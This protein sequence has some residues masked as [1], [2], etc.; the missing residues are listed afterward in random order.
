MALWKLQG[1]PSNI[2]ELGRTGVKLEREL[3]KVDNA[4]VEKK[5]ARKERQVRCKVEVEVEDDSSK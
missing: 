5:R 1:V 3:D 4:G 2:R